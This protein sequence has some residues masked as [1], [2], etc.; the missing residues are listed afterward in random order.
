VG[1]LEDIRSTVPLEQNFLGGWRKTVLFAPELQRAR[2]GSS[3]AWPS[4]PLTQ[5]IPERSLVE[6]KFGERKC[7]G[8]AFNDGV[9]ASL[10]EFGAKLP[11]DTGWSRDT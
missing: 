1:N 6:E 9:F 11:A 7:C 3:A 5:A 10:P 8:V 2:I 4:P